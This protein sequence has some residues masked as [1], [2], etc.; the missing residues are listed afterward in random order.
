MANFTSLTFLVLNFDP[1]R[2]NEKWENDENVQDETRVEK[3]SF[4]SNF[5]H[6]FAVPH[7]FASNTFCLFFLSPFSFNFMRQAKWWNYEKGIRWWKRICFSLFFTIF[8]LLHE[9]SINHCLLLT[10]WYLFFFCF[11]SSLAIFCS[12][13]SSFPWLF[14][15]L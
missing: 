7:E 12:S 8:L 10:S 4:K 1:K 11:C 2:R 5:S 14:I 6:F 15:I 9:R 3:E 13:L